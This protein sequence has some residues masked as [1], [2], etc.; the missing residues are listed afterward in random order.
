MEKRAIFS[1]QFLPYLLLAPQ[2]AITIVFFY[3]PAS[4]AVRQSFFIEDA[5]GTKSDFV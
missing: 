4:Q 3:L 5:F 1:H 2:L